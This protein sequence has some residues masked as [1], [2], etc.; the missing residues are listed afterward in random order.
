MPRWP[1]CFWSSDPTVVANESGLLSLQ[2]VAC[3][4]DDVAIPTPLLSLRAPARPGTEGSAASALYKRKMT[5]PAKVN[6][7]NNVPL[8]I[9]EENLIICAIRVL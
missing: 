9:G 3:G 4:R 7:F 1:F 5:L 8:H 6:V 2:G